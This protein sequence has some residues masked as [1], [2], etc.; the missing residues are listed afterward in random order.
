[1]KALRPI[2]PYVLIWDMNIRGENGGLMR[3][4]NG[5]PIPSDNKEG[6]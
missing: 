2:K 4:V 3:A 5:I 6:K 1:M